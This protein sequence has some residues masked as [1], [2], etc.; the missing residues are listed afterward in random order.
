[1]RILWMQQLSLKGC[2]CFESERIRV[3]FCMTI[4]HILTGT[5]KRVRLE[6]IRMTPLV[7]LLCVSNSR[8]GSMWCGRL[9]EVHVEPEGAVVRLGSIRSTCDRFG[10]GPEICGGSGHS[11]CLHGNVPT[12][13]LERNGGAERNDPPPISRPDGI[14]KAR[15]MRWM[16]NTQLMRSASPD[17]N[18]RV[19]LDSHNRKEKRDVRNRIEKVTKE[20]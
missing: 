16:D 2:G 19:R 20:A 3:R 12:R 14:P 9:L 6:L 13:I 15:I 17:L 5:V 18:A 10:C 7:W 8:C 1:V 4:G 11:M